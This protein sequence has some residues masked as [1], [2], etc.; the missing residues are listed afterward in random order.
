MVMMLLITTG[1]IT[2]IVTI[3]SITTRVIILVFSINNMLNSTSRS[4]DHIDISI[5][6]S[7]DANNAINKSFSLAINT[8]IKGKT[9]TTANTTTSQNSNGNDNINNVNSNNSASTINNETQRQ[10]YT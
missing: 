1:M 7:N 9:T 2:I 6:F 4:N 10:Y 3:V 8:T 5:A